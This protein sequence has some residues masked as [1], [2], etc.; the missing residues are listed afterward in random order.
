M[1]TQRAAAYFPR[2][3]SAY[4]QI[5]TAPSGKSYIVSSGR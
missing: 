3:K 1:L 4:A 5:V 2:W